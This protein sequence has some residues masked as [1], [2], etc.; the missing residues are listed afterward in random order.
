MSF[1]GG[2]VVKRNPPYNARDV[3]VGLIPRS[4]IPGREGNSNPLQYFCLESPMDKGAWQA[5]IHGVSKSW[6]RLSDFTFFL[7][8]LN[9][10]EG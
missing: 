10:E 5:T 2:S 7:S 6:T 3:D 8:L 4:R 9:C 1:P